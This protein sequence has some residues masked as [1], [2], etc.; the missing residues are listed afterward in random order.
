VFTSNHVTE[1]KKTLKQLVS[2]FANGVWSDFKA[3]NKA[4]AG[5][6]TKFGAGA[7]LG[8]PITNYYEAY[9]PVQ[10]ALRGFGPLPAEFT[11]SGA[12]QVFEYTTAQRALIVARA[13]AVRFVLITA[14]YEGGVLIGSVINQTLP[15]K[16][17]DA[18]GGTINE[19][20]N[21]GGWRLLFKHPFGYGM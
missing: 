19:I 11:K 4:T 12:I 17:Q 18:I 2:S 6:L 21:E 15:E 20:V 3:T 7:A 13:A 16:V 1:D 10:W 14:A 5:K 8:G 9:S